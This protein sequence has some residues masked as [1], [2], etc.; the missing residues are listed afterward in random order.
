MLTGQASA[1]L[2]ALA[3]AAAPPRGGR[4]AESARRLVKLRH[5]A[6][7]E[8]VRGRAPSARR[9]VA[10]PSPSG[11][12]IEPPPAETSLAKLT[13][14]AI[15]ERLERHGCILVR[16]LVPA[17]LVSRL[18][19]AIDQAF[20][21][22]DAFAEKRAHDTGWFDP[23]LG[24]D[25][26]MDT[27][28]WVRKAGGVLAADSPLGLATL[29]DTY[30]ELGVVRLIADYFGERPAVS[31]DKATLR[32]TQLTPDTG[33][34][35]DGRFLGSGIRSLNVWVAL[36]DCGVDAPSLDIVPT[37]PNRI[38]ETGNEGARFDWT[39][40]H[41]VVLREFGAE[42][43]WQPIFHAG[44]ALLFDHMLVHRTDCRAQM[45]RLRHALETWFF[46]PS[47]YPSKQTPLLV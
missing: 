27:R 42:A 15:R 34:H 17:Q 30:A 20:A 41:D 14:A 35:Q 32:R 45:T 44:D 13:P 11:Q 4:D 7:Q 33:W 31:A 47:A 43:I 10:P 5:A 12:P 22:Y 6:F 16:G 36:T 46:A 18:V 24:I 28:G 21:A 8:L 37:Y 1:A 38:L 9:P 25:G 3:S 40:G 39:I 23:A 19:E 26:G 2:D 29:L